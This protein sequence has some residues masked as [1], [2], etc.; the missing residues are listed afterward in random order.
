MCS[1][2][3]HPFGHASSTIRTTSTALAGVSSPPPETVGAN[4]TESGAVFA[5]RTVTLIGGYVAPGAS[6]SVRVHV[7]V[8]HVPPGPEAAAGP[9]PALKSLVS[10]VRPAG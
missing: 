8:A 2:G 5:V 4:V 3:D 9:A 6:A 1:S 10:A 7:V